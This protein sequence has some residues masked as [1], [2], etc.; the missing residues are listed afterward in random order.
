VVDTRGIRH[1]QL[2]T[3]DE[4]IGAVNVARVDGVVGLV[5]DTLSKCCLVASEPLWDPGIGIGPIDRVL[6]CAHLVM[7]AL[8]EASHQG[9]GHPV[10]QREELAYIGI[11]RENW[12][13][14]EIGSFSHLYTS[15]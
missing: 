5:P 8:D 4:E 6:W 9:L 12:G 15:S 11:E 2:L 13:T 3:V 14:N 10:Q 1:K 7:D